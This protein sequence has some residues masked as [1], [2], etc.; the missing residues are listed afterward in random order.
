MNLAATEKSTNVRFLTPLLI[1]C[2]LL[3]GCVALPPPAAQ[4]SECDVG[5]QAVCAT[6]GPERS[7]ECQ[8]RTDIERFLT[9]L[10]EPAWLG[11]TH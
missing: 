10:G 4:R 9:T 5:L 11:G 7:C 8:P 2:S 3:G 6:F 1:A